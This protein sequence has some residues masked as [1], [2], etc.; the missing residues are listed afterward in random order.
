[1]VLNNGSVEQAVALEKAIDGLAVALA[2]D[3][4]VRLDGSTVRLPPYGGA[5]LRA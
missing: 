3:D 1:M 4:A 2:T 5:I